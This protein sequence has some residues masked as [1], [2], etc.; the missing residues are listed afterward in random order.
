MAIKTTKFPACL[1]QT[2]GRV[3]VATV[4]IGQGDPE[5]YI[6]VWSRADDVSVFGA[7]SWVDSRG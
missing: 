5:P 4:A 1:Q 3:H 2:L 6:R 7:G